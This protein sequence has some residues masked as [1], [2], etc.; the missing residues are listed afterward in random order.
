MIA[1][2]RSSTLCIVL[3]IM[4][5]ILNVSAQNDSTAGHVSIER[6]L[7]RSRSFVAAGTVVYAGGLLIELVGASML[8]SNINGG[9]VP[10]QVSQAVLYTGGALDMAGPILS[11]TGGTIANRAHYSIHGYIRRYRG[12][13]LYAGSWAAFALSTGLGIGAGQALGAGRRAAGTVLTIGSAIGGLCS[14]GLRTASVAHT[15]AFI[16]AVSS[17]V[18]K[19]Q[20][21]TASATPSFDS[22]G[23]FGAICTIV[24]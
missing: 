8:M 1:A 7:R 3:I 12:W 15:L 9:G 10:L 17:S 23:N 20:G 16:T 14:L 19:Q 24:F 18:R 2:K 13:R 11:A 4:A 22:R 21:I 5:G 6:T